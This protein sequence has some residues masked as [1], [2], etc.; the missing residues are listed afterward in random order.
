VAIVLRHPAGTVRDTGDVLG[1]VA[2]TV[3]HLQRL[4]RFT[5]RDPRAKRDSK[6]P[7]TEHEELVN[8]PGEAIRRA[9]SK[10]TPTVYVT[11]R[12]RPLRN[13]MLTLQTPG[14]YSVFARSY[15]RHLRLNRLPWFAGASDAQAAGNHERETL[16]FQGEFS[17]AV[18]RQK[19]GYSG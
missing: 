15:L 10:K 13:Q 17:Y 18:P 2:R 9:R 11:V 5:L 3:D 19:A 6:A 1:T 12:L 14:V 4:R 8:S 7:R 16:T